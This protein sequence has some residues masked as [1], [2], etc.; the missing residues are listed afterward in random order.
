MNLRI[1]PNSCGVIYRFGPPQ[2][3]N[4]QK[5]VFS[6]GKSLWI[7]VSKNGI[8]AELNWGYVYDGIVAEYKFGKS[9]ICRNS[10]GPR[11]YYVGH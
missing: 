9:E 5:C 6:K 11:T 1:C 3:E 10:Y 4:F 7:L 2:A 8:V